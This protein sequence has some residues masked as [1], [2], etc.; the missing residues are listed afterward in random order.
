MLVG[1]SDKRPVLPWTTLE[2]AS[3]R[4]NQPASGDT[5]HSESLVRQQTTTK[6]YSLSLTRADLQFL[7]YQSNHITG[8]IRSPNALKQQNKVRV[9]PTFY[10]SMEK[11]KF[12]VLAFCPHVLFRQV[13]HSKKT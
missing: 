8:I 4:F 11:L 5:Q 3:F 2:C 10:Q 7:E 13:Q 12:A 1:D 9:Y 6:S